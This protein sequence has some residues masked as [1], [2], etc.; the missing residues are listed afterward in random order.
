MIQHKWNRSL[1]MS[2]EEQK[3]PTQKRIESRST[4]RKKL[5]ILVKKIH[6]AKC[7]GHEFPPVEIKE[8]VILDMDRREKRATMRLVEKGKVIIKKDLI[9]EEKTK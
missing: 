6:K 2:K 4:H 1:G 5:M 9:K 7:N 8:S 3:L